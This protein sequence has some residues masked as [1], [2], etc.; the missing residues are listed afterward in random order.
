M[1]TC[2]FWTGQAFDS[3]RR[4]NVYEAMKDMGIPLKLVKLMPMGTRYTIAKIKYDNM[5]S[6]SFTLSELSKVKV[7]GQPCL[8]YTSL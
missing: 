7:V 6:E 3:V 4:V 5:L 1:F 2:C 8:L